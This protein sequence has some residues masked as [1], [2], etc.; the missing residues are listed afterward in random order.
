MFFTSAFCFK[1]RKLGCKITLNAC[2]VTNNIEKTLQN[3]LASGVDCMPKMLLV[4]TFSKLKMEPT[5][6]PMICE[7]LVPHVN[8]NSGKWFQRGPYWL[9]RTNHMKKWTRSSYF[10]RRHAKSMVYA[11]KLEIHIQRVIGEIRP[12]MIHKMMK[13]VN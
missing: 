4:H 12:V 10:L 9:D 3:F 1:G 13:F 7:F 2:G 8:I 5:I 6:L 11:D